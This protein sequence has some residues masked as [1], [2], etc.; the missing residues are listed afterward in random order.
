MSK[1]LR[2]HYTPEQKTELLKKHLMG[3]VP[4]SNLCDENRLQPSV[5]Y[6]WQRRLFEMGHLA[7]VEG[8]GPSRREQE[9]EQRVAF[10][11][12][13]LAKKDSVIAE[14]SQEYVQ[15][16]KQLGEL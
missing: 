13:K 2:R 7:F 4:I 12:A 10:L 15:L 6:D 3:K 8:K 9:L 11:E 16:K 1:K 14:V 5:F